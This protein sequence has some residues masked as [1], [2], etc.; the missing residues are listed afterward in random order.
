MTAL[1][2]TERRKQLI[3]QAEANEAAN[4]AAYQ[5]QIDEPE[6]PRKAPAP[7]V[8]T[9]VPNN[10]PG[11]NRKIPGTPAGGTM[12]PTDQLPGNNRTVQGTP[13]P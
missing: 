8:S 10:S 4:D 6:N 7:F 13:A 3:A 5:Q 11:N 9:P 1:S 2:I 12:N